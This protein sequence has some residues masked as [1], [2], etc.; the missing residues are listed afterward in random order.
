MSNIWP[1]TCFQPIGH[2]F[3]IQPVG[4]LNLIEISFEEIRC[5]YYIT[6]NI[7]ANPGLIHVSNKLTT[8]IIYYVENILLIPITI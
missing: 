5:D 7:T 2:E 8:N 1:F 4:S 6:K 3:P